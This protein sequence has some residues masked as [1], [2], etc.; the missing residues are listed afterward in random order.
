[1]AGGA[2]PT[3]QCCTTAT[4]CQYGTAVKTPT[5][6]PQ[7]SAVI[8]NTG[9]LCDFVTD[10]TQKKNCKSCFEAGKSWTALGCIATKPD[11]FITQ[12]LGLGIGIG[13]GIAFLLILF[14]GFQMMTSSGNPERLTAGRELVSAAISGLLLIIFS[15]FL[16]RLIGY[17]ILRIPGFK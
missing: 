10:A 3:S 6:K 1:L 12:F 8:Q 2:I 14:G 11:Q 7:S 16:L 15:V 4:E 17:D 13:G 9:K 5:P